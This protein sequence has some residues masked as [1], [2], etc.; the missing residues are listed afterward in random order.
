V[1]AQLVPRTWTES[2]WMYSAAQLDAAVSLAEE[3]GRARATEP[4]QRQH[5]P[6]TVLACS[7]CGTVAGG[8]D[9]DGRSWLTVV[10]PGTAEPLACDYCPDCVIDCAACQ[11]AAETGRACQRCRGAGRSPR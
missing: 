1:I 5:D 10:I 9:A 7:R 8:H 11:S 6:L 3:L 4:L 2:G